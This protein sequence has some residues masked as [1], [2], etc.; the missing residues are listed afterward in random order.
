MN[1]PHKHAALIKAWADG[2]EIQFK[3]AAGHWTDIKEPTW[4]NEAEY[5]IKPAIINY[6]VCLFHCNKK[7]WTN[8]ADTMGEASNLEKSY[9]FV[10][11]L[12][13]WIEVEV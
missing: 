1:K 3:N 8:I 12:T 7:H 11:W 4:V 9:G 10:R 2:A 6:R 13:N 5:R